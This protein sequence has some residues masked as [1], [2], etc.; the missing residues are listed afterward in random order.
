MADMLKVRRLTPTPNLA[1]ALR[2]HVL[3]ANG[4]EIVWHGGTAGYRI[5]HR[6]RPEG[7]RRRRRVVERGPGSRSG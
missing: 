2:W 1:V 6:L 5:V 7:A 4:K 3:T